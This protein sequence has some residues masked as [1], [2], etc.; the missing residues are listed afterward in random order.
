MAGIT[1]TIHPVS[2]FVWAPLAKIA[3]DMQLSPAPGGNGHS[4]DDPPQG[5]LF[6]DPDGETHIFVF[7]EE[8]RQ[9]L[10]AA[11]TGGIVLPNVTPQ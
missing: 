2:N 1:R 10:L 8:G 7:G 5:L 3:P 6:V 4:P 9:K 11:L